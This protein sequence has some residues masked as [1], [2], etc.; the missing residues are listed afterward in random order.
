M[1]VQVSVLKPVRTFFYYQKFYT[2]LAFYIAGY[3][4]K[5]H[6]ELLKL[7]LPEKLLSVDKQVGHSHKQ[8]SGTYTLYAAVPDKVNEKVS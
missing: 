1:T 4:H 2:P 5:R 3:S 6:N 7:L 8:T